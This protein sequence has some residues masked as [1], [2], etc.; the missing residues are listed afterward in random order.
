MIVERGYRL[1][2]RALPLYSTWP[3]VYFKELSRGLVS[4]KTAPLASFQSSANLSRAGFAG[5]PGK[6]PIAKPV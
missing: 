1:G 2:L 3:H 4:P 6:T 5:L